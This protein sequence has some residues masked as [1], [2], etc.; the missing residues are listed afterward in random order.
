MLLVPPTFELRNLSSNLSSNLSRI[1][2]APNGLRGSIGRALRRLRG[3]PKQGEQG[4]QGDF[5]QPAERECV[6]DSVTESVTESVTA[7]VTEGVTESAPIRTEPQS[8]YTVPSLSTARR[9]RVWLGLLPSRD[10]T[11]PRTANIIK[12]KD[13]EL[14]QIESADALLAFLA[15][16]FP[17]IKD[18][19][20]FVT[21][22]EAE[23]F[24]Q[25][26]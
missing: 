9:R 16:S 25:E 3:R 13:H 18:I 22:A 6:T 21:R 12:P 8:A 19:A 4:E 17:Q 15:A 20:G 10:P 26:H 23:G 14:W 24:V 2:A 7:S 1:S 11:V 5:L